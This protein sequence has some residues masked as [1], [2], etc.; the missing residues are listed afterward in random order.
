MLVRLRHAYINQ[1]VKVDVTNIQEIDLIRVHSGIAGF[2]LTNNDHGEAYH[3]YKSFNTPRL[4]TKERIIHE[5]E[6]L[7]V[8]GKN[9]Y[10]QGVKKFNEIK[11]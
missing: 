11:W 4:N 3:T 2:L 5:F 9:D 8:F 10:N 7:L 1:R 6:Y